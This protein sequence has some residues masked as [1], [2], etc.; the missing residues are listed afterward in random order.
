MRPIPFGNR[1]LVQRDQIET[2]TKAGIY[3]PDGKKEPPST[4]V[5]LAVG[6]GSWTPEGT[7][8]PVRVDEGDR[9]AFPNYAGT[10]LKY[11]GVSYLLMTEADILALLP[12]QE[13]PNDPQ[14]P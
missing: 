5:V 7:R 1:I 9:I 13:V 12:P 11:E 3:L 14:V 6:K 4:G 10:E 8:I 2:K